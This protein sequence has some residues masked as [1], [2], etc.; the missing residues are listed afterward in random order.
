MAFGTLALRKAKDEDVPALIEVGVASCL[1]SIDEL[2]VFRDRKDETPAAF[3][4]FVPEQ[5]D[6]T[7]VLE[8]DGTIAGF[9]SYDAETGEITDVW[10]DPS[11]Q[12]KGYGSVLLSA[13]E[14]VLKQAGHSCTWLTTHANNVGA[15]RFYRVQGY[16]LLSID[17]APGQTLPDV[18]YPRALLGKQL[19][20]PN[21]EQASTMEEVRQGIDTLDPMLVSLFAERFAFIDKA[22]DV[23]SRITMPARV[24]SRVEQVV[25]NAR[26]QAERIGFDPDLTETFWRAMIEQ[27]IRR[28]EI[29]MQGELGETGS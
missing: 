15:L 25:A 6:S 5:I 13:A 8:R 10:L 29:H 19:S 28:E 22:A 12:G 1:S 23:K 21:A 27:A 18:T 2:P 17:E 26:R 3:A 20:R 16:A 7:I 24:T 14:A 9:A 11:V 4:R